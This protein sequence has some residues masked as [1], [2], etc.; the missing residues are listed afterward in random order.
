MG[1]RDSIHFSPGGWLL[2]RLLI[3][4]S[5]LLSLSDH[6]SDPDLPSA[7]PRL[8]ISACPR[9]GFPRSSVGKE[10]A[11]NVGD[12]DLIPGLGRSPGEGSGNPLQYSC[13]ENQSPR[14]RSLAVTRARHDLATKPPPLFVQE[15]L[16]QSFLSLAYKQKIWVMRVVTD[17]IIEAKAKFHCCR[18][19]SVAKLCLTFCDPTDCLLVHHSIKVCWNSYPLSRWC[20]PTISSS[21]IPFSE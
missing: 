5:W 14:Q 18:H 15:L 4:D 16:F 6:F 11:Y 3:A 8:S 1:H 20:H 12:P 19:C 2:P 7:S 13:L 9:M 21:T 17:K 10:L